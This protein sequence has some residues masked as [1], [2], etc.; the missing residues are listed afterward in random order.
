MKVSKK[1]KE[2]Y[3]NSHQFLLN[4]KII[5]KTVRKNTSN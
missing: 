1:N 2:E 3:K 4:K 5:I